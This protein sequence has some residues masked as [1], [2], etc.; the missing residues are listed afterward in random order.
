MAPNLARGQMYHVMLLYHRGDHEWV[1]LLAQKLQSPSIGL[2]CFC[3][4]GDFDPSGSVVENIIQ[5]FSHSRKTV[6]VLSH[7]FLRETWPT[8]RI[9]LAAILEGKTVTR[10]RIV[11]VAIDDCEIPSC[12]AGL[13]YL[14]RTDSADWYPALLRGLDVDGKVSPFQSFKSITPI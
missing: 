4:D 11:V 6:L 12:L 8:C 13:P 14:V 2:Q 7:I 10:K 5:A 9:K 1:F 3:Q